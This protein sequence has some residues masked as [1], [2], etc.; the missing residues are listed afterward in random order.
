M[1]GPKPDPLTLSDAE[2]TEVE[3]LVR[4]HGTAQQ[5]ALRGGCVAK[6]QGG[7]RWA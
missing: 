5:L 3:A 1:R 6:N 2:R 7:M 4:R